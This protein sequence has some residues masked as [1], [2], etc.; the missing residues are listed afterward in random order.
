MA[1]R[2]AL[3]LLLLSALPALAQD[4]VAQVKLLPDAKKGTAEEIDFQVVAS[5]GAEE[6]ELSGKLRREIVAVEDELPSSEKLTILSGNYQHREQYSSHGTSPPLNQPKTV[7]RAGKARTA[8]LSIAEI[9]LG[10]EY[11]HTK[12]VTSALRRDFDALCRAC[13]TDEKVK[14]DEK[15]GLEPEELLYPITGSK[16]KLLEGSKATAT[17][18]ALKTR[19]GKLEGVITVKATIFFSKNDDPDTKCRLGIEA[20]I[21]GPVDGSGPPKKEKVNL[22]FKDG[23][24]AKWTETVTL[25]RTAAEKDDDADDDAPKKDKKDGPKFGVSCDDDMVVQTVVEGSLAEKA[26]IKKG[27]KLLELGGKKVASMDDLKKAVQDASGEV[28][29]KL[30]RDEKEKEIKVTF[31][32]KKKKDDD[33]K[34]PDEDKKPD[35]KKDEGKKKLDEDKKKDD[36]KKDE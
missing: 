7:K 16:V 15:W 32:G 17:L 6:E 9:N 12:D 18:D 11:K 2:L 34:K 5:Y 4:E 14:V 21:R 31:P 29:V 23:D 8:S 20:T 22:S 10:R 26:G 35:E 3:G 19:D 33:K 1:P 13:Q 25:E 24:G 27:D 36:E 28:K 30:S